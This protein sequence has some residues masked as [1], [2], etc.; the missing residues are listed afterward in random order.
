MSSGRSILAFSKMAGLAKISALLMPALMPT[1]LS[2][3]LPESTVP[4]ANFETSTLEIQQAPAVA[5][6]GDVVHVHLDDVRRLPPAVWVASL[7]Q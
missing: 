3:I 7:S 1:S 5:V 6:L 4:S 2:L